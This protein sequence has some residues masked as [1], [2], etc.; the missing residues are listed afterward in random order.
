MQKN[1]HKQD[2]ILFSNPYSF[3]IIYDINPYMNGRIDREKM[4]K[5]W[6]NCVRSVREYSNIETVD[7]NIFPQD[8]TKVVDLPDIV[9]CANHGFC[10]DKKSF[11]VSNMKHKERIP[12]IQYFKKWIN[13]KEYK[14]YELSEDSYFEGGGDAK[15]HPDMSHIWMGYG[16][17]TNKNAIDEIRSKIDESIIEL[18]LTN[19]NYY[20]LDVCFEP[21]DEETAIVIK[22]AFTPESYEKIDSKFNDLIHIP[23]E[24]YK[25]FA[26]N[27]SKISK[28][29]IV[30][31]KDNK[32]TI[33]ILEKNGYNTITVNTSEFMKAGGSIDCL[34]LKVWN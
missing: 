22:D 10:I 23:K 29:N 3:R 5:Q 32:E 17:R 20:H 7:Y 15:W 6:H 25:T 1:K 27:C 34:L 18:E 13:M 30:I 21:L 8:T 33:R 31:D 12:E 9:F 19:P 28:S 26:G 11:I 14:L 4:W 2:F 24:D 16:I